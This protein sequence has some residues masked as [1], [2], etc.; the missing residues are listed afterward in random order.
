M[1]GKTLFQPS[2]YTSSPARLGEEDVHAV[3]VR[4]D[5]RPEINTTNIKGGTGLHMY[6]GVVEEGARGIL[7]EKTFFIEGTQ[8][9]DAA[10]NVLASVLRTVGQ[11]GD[12]TEDN[13]EAWCNSI[14]TT[15]SPLKIV[16]QEDPKNP[17][18]RRVQFLNSPT[19]Y[20]DAR[21]VYA[22][23]ISAMAD[24]AEQSSTRLALAA[25]GN[26]DVAL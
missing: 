20:G 21:E 22:E 11:S 24:L 5:F 19:A 10:R 6:F 7:L 23:Q 3:I 18:Y 14:A 17:K 16:T 13:L 25:G 1:S 8:N 9:D 15:S 26:E 12:L 2:L 4:C